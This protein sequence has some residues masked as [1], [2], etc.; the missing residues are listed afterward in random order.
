V[1]L[2]FW[3]N[4]VDAT[5]QNRALEDEQLDD[6]IDNTLVSALPLNEPLATCF[7]IHTL[8]SGDFGLPTTFPAHLK[9][10]WGDL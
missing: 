3:L 7:H 8:N 5:H 2:G 1:V 10:K 6:G 4:P 9:G